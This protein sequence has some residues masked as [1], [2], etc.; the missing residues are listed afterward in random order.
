MVVT[1]CLHQVP[2]LHQWL[3]MFPALGLQES[4]LRNDYEDVTLTVKSWGKT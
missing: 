1:V 2:S 4:A 3:Q